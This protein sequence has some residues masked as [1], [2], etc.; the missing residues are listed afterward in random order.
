[1]VKRQGI[2][3]NQMTFWKL[4]NLFAVIAGVQLPTLDTHYD[5]RVFS[6]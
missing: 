3:R 2:Y 6:L 4:N 5:K 1:M